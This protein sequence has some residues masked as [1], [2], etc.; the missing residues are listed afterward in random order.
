MRG[1]S[2][3]MGTVFSI[4]PATGAETVLY[5]SCSQQQQNCTDAIYPEAGL[6]YVK[7]TLYG[8]AIAGGANEDCGGSCGAVFSIDPNSGAEKVIHSFNENGTDGWGPYAGLIYTKGALYGTTSYGGSNCV[9]SG[10]CG[11]VFSINLKKGTE[12][13]V[14]SFCSQQNC[15]DGSIPEAGL[16][17]VDG[18]LYGTT[19][20]GGTLDSFGTVFSIDPTTR[21]EAVVHA[22]AGAPDGAVPVAGLIDV[23]G[24]LYGTTR[25]GGSN[26]EGSVF[27]INT[28]TG[29]ET[30]AH[31]FGGGGDGIY[32]YAAVVKIGGKL[33]GTAIE[34]GSSSYCNGNGCGAVFEIT[35]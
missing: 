5:S 12:T 25:A 27:S 14:Y 6:L 18:A 7:G 3:D 15:A 20:S 33:Y 31:S 26:Q 11:T 19:E 9:N 4:N 10:G 30:V 35:P 28:Q 16:L 22:F 1:G 29:T 21:T 32:P 23:G 17:N 8:T 2:Q 13:V 34:G 24:F